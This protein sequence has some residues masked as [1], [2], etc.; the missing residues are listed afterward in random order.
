MILAELALNKRHLLPFKNDAAMIG[1][2]CSL[3]GFEEKDRGL[4]R[5]ELME[6]VVVERGKGWESLASKKQLD[7]ALVALVK[8]MLQINPAKR[9]TLEQVITHPAFKDIQLE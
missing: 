4:V 9:P 8:G 6:S 2:I 1:Q 7:P 5:R 3:C